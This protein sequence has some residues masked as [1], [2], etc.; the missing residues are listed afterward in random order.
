MGGGGVMYAICG[1]KIHFVLSSVESIF[2]LRSWL[3]KSY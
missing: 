1:S 2:T 3:V